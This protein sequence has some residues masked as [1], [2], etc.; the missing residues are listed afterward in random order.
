MILYETDEVR[1]KTFFL[2]QAAGWALYAI[3]MFWFCETPYILMETEKQVSFFNSTWHDSYSHP[4]PNIRIGWANMAAVHA[5]ILAGMCIFCYWTPS[6]ISL[7][8]SASLVAMYHAGTLLLVLRAGIGLMP[9]SYLA[10]LLTGLVFDS[11]AV[12]QGHREVENI[13]VE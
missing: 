9:P 1:F 2:L 6:A 8:R 3:H 4:R 12:F 13:K 11:Y 10:F 7:V 5:Y